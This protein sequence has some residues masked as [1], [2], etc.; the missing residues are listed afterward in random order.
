MKASIVAA[1]ELS[2]AALVTFEDKINTLFHIMGQKAADYV[3]QKVDIHQQLEEKYKRKKE[4]MDELGKQKGKFSSSSTC[5]P[6][7][8]IS[9]STLTT[10]C[11]S[12]IESY[13]LLSSQ[14]L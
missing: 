4:L 2:T 12:H 9:L 3:N 11:H 14:A 13:K 10:F 1:G 5:V 6:T 7:V 8:I